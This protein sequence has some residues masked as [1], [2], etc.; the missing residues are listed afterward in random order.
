MPHLCSWKPP[1]NILVSLWRPNLLSYFS[2]AFLHCAIKISPLIL[3]NLPMRL[4]PRTRLHMW[5]KIATPNKILL[6][7]KQK[8]TN[9]NKMKGFLQYP[10]PSNEKV[11]SMSLK[12]L[13][14]VINAQVHFYG[15]IKIYQNKTSMWLQCDASILKNRSGTRNQ[16]YTKQKV[17]NKGCSQ[18]CQPA[19]VRAMWSSE[20]LNSL[21]STPRQLHGYMDTSLLI[22]CSEIRMDGYSLRRKNHEYTKR[23]VY[24]KTLENSC[25]R[26]LPPEGWKA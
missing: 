21:V 16:Q 15:Q 9:K 24:Q 23:R 25:R 8:I 5:M 3:P 17:L 18:W 11:S 19:L 22:C 4:M 26:P 7:Y 6:L 12:M 14:N 20:L 13:L 2:K 1:K 10:K